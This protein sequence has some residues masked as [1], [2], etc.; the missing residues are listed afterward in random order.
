M[1]ETRYRLKRERHEV[2]RLAHETSNGLGYDT[3]LL[4]PSATL[5]QHFEIELLARKSFQ[6]VLADSAELALI[7]VAKQT[8]FEIGIAEAPGVIVAQ[9]ALDMSRRQDLAY[10]V[11]D[12][13]VLQC[14]AD[15]LQLL[16]QP[17]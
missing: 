17:L 13:I 10:D 6:S 2:G 7:H 15:L 12:G 16:K 11:E 9:N 8:L 3:L 14:V 5:D 1:R 4:R